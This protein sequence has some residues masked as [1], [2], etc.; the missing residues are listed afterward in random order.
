VPRAQ[1]LPLRVHLLRL[2]AGYRCRH[3]GVCCTEDWAIPVE[4][5]LYRQLEGALESK[6]LRPEHV[7]ASYFEPA[8][9]LPAGEPVV[10]GRV[11]RECAF[12]EPSR[13]RLCA[14]H[15]QLGHDALPS[16][17]QHFPRVVAIDPRGVFVSLSHVCPT[18]G[19]LLVEPAVGPFEIVN[20]GPLV[21]PGLQWT[22]LDAREALPPQVSAETLWDWEALTV[23]ERGILDLLARLSPERALS[24]AADA[25]RGIE[26]WRPGGTDTLETATKAALDTAALE[27]GIRRI[28]VDRLDGIAR[29][30]A[31]ATMPSHAPPLD[32]SRGDEAFVQ[33]MWESLGPLVGRYLASR[34]IANATGY[35]AA[36]AGVWAASLATAYAVL[37]TEASRQAM[38]AGRL[39]DANLLIAAAADADRLLVHR[40]DA[41]RL[42][43]A[44]HAL[45]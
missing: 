39:L 44:L 40:V 38:S 7:G 19:R 3:A 9:G 4:A 12:F 28:D 35:H 21:T 27:K 15:G 33:P 37:R 24:A 14:I 17:C 41:A 36:S 29:E 20:G 5:P 16:A 22:G 25:A 34:A 23:W 13:G 42:A 1:S 11:G 2:H 8:H 31:P 30:A 32:R 10:T 26:R 43:R 6:A 45:S 18:A